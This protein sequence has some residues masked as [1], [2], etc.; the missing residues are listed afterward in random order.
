M[1]SVNSEMDFCCDKGRNSTQT[2]GQRSAR[3]GTPAERAPQIR[4]LPDTEWPEIDPKSVVHPKG[5]AH[6]I[7]F[8]H[9][10][11][12]TAAEKLV[13]WVV[14]K[15]PSVVVW[16][17]DPYSEEEDSFTILLPWIQQR[18]KVEN[19]IPVQLAAFVRAADTET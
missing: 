12:A 7:N 17:G 4:L 8:G 13:T 5:F 2:N 15:K 1:G 11:P 16:D 18:C 3:T 10:H 14:E 9:M 6:R 19:G